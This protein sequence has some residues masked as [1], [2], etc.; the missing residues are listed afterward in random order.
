MD[1][2]IFLVL[3]SS[4]H[5]TATFSQHKYAS[6]ILIL[7]ALSD[8]KIVATPLELDVKL[9]PTDDAPFND[10]TCHQ[11]IVGC[12]VYL[13]ISCPDITYVHLLGQ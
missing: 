13:T 9:Q 5:P 7:A 10:P 2:V 8:F 6:D 12:F 4:H 11:E 3:K 1:F